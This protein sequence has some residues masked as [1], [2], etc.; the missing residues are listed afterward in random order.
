M[1]YHRSPFRSLRFSLACYVSGTNFGHPTIQK[2]PR[3]SLTC[4]PHSTLR[5]KDVPFCPFGEHKIKRPS[6]TLTPWESIR[7]LETFPYRRSRIVYPSSLLS[8]ADRFSL[9]T[10]GTLL[11]PTLTVTSYF[12]EPGCDVLCFFS[13]AN[14]HLCARRDEHLFR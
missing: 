5:N 10:F 8:M 12:H 14:I 7:D 1:G 11:L 4:D 3:S 6:P 13:M 9:N 2:T